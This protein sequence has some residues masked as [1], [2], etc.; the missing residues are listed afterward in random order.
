MSKKDNKFSKTI[1]QKLSSSYIT[2]WTS[3]VTGRHH[4]LKRKLWAGVACA[5]HFCNF[6]Q[7]SRH[8]GLI[9]YNFPFRVHILCTCYGTVLDNTAVPCMHLH[10]ICLCW[11]VAPAGE[12]YYNTLLCCD[13]YFSSSSVV[14]NA[15]SALCVYLKFGHHPHP[16]G[17]LCAKFCFFCGL[18]CWAS[19]WRKTVYS[20]NHSITHS[21]SLFDLGQPKL[22]LRKM[23]RNRCTYCFMLFF[24]C[25]CLC[26]HF[27]QALQ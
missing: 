6:F 20:I 13:D 12:C 3:N 14:S 26:V 17:Y 1:T 16:L 2:N 4:G 21:P 9:V 11:Y 27:C 7:Y 10:I 25:S 24:Q 8:L 19:P 15:F 23:N 18:H 5:P 22:A